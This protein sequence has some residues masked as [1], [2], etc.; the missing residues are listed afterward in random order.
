M[1]LLYMK[2]DYVSKHEKI[3]VK[4]ELGKDLYLISGKWGRVGDTLSLY[5]ID[6]TMLVKVKQTVLSL[7]PKFDIYIQ[8]KR[9]GS[10]TK[11]RNLKNVYFKVAPLDW[12]VTG[13]FYNHA[14]TVRCKGQLIMEMNKSYTSFG[15]YYTLLIPE[16]QHAPICICLALIVDDLTLTRLPDVARKR[17]IRAIRP[18]YSIRKAL[19]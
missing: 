4:N 6:G 2:Q 10:I 19:I 3:L 11:H 9:A 5:S 16:A 12:M 17:F 13:D 1:V 18:L 15:D 7:L 8:G 14:Y